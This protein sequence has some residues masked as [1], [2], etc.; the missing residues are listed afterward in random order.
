MA[1]EVQQEGRAP[2][3]IVRSIL[4]IASGSAL[5]SLIGLAASP[6]ITRLFTPEEF[7]VFSVATATA[8]VLLSMV[9]GRMD[10]AL[11]IPSADSEARAL[12][13]LGV[14]MAVISI[15]L[16]TVTTIVWPSMWTA[17]VSDE[18]KDQH[19]LAVPVL[20]VPMSA[21][22]LL[23]AWAVRQGRYRQIATRS[24]LQS[25]ATAAAQLVAGAFALGS[26][27]LIGGF[28]VGQFVGAASLAIGAGLTR[29]RTHET[30][31]L[32]AA[33]RAYRR[34][35]LILAPAGSVNALGMQAPLLIVAST[36]GAHEAG[37][38][39]LAQRMLAAPAAMMGQSVAQVYTGELAKGMRKGGG[40][41]LLTL[42]WKTTRLLACGGCVLAFIAGPIAFVSF[43]AIFGTEWGQSGTVAAIL[44]FGVAAQVLGAP[45]SQTLALLQRVWTMAIW[46]MTRLVATGA[47]LFICWK[48][49]GSLIDATLTLSLVMMAMYALYWWLSYRALT[50]AA[51]GQRHHSDA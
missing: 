44:A 11:P 10:L 6:L 28:F 40:E 38:L 9:T 4:A 30:S 20:L 41:A 34:Y 36:Y 13:A 22:L 2:A 37:V 45:V 21:Y 43:G 33:T 29:G 12:L 47:G 17:V 51:R 31:E 15:S 7:G 46:D 32:L 26:L 8:V 35:P 18:L 14:M 48:L 5:G 23:N 1:G 42:F 49:G 3:S 25:S 19:L 16:I 50:N 39:A 27:G 24:I